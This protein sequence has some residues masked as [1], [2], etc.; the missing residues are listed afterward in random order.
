MAE[1]PQVIDAFDQP[2]PLSTIGTR[3]E[4]I[5]DQV[6]GGVSTGTSVRE[7]VDGRSA[8]RMRGVV[9]LENDGGFVQ[10]A[11]DLAP[12]G[13]LVDATAWA[14]IEIDVRGNGEHYNVHLR[15]A[16][17]VRPWQS[18]R[19]GFVA[20]PEW[21]TIRLPFVDFEPHRI[22]ARL[23][24][25]RL[26]RVGIVAIGRAFVADVAIGGLRFYR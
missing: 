10:V 23:D 14:G 21:R 11:L 24:R 6:M 12:R 16:D 25:M 26:R 20:S 18:Y 17:V 1:P 7:T 2:H 9:S 22:E 15:S 3:W 8:L 4:L 19:A 13:G 5:A